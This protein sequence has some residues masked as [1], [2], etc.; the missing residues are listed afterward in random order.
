MPPVDLHDGGSLLALS[1]SLVGP[2]NRLLLALQSLLQPLKLNTALDNFETT[3]DDEGWTTRKDGRGNILPAFTDFSVFNTVQTAELMERVMQVMHILRNFSF[4]EHH[5]RFSYPQHSILTILAK[6][7]ALPSYSWYTEVKQYSLDIFENLAGC[8]QLRGKNDFYLA[9]LKKMIFEQN[10]VIVM[11]ALRS[12]TRLCSNEANHACLSEIDP[13]I[14]SKLFQFLYVKDED[15]VYAILEFIYVHTCLGIDVSSKIASAAPANAI[16]LLTSVLKL[17]TKQNSSHNSMSNLGRSTQ[18]SVRQQNPDEILAVSWLRE[19]YDP[20]PNSVL[21]V[22]DL[23]ADYQSC[24]SR[25]PALT[26]GF[27]RALLFLK[28]YAPGAILVQNEVRGLR[29]RP[30]FVNSGFAGTPTV[31]SEFDKAS[32]SEDEEEIDIDGDEVL[33]EGDAS[34]PNRAHN[35]MMNPQLD[36]SK[37]QSLQG[38]MD[39]I[40]TQSPFQYPNFQTSTNPT[41]PS[42]LPYF[43]PPNM[44]HS[45]SMNTPSAPRRRGR[46]PK[47]RAPERFSHMNTYMGS[48]HQFQVMYAQQGGLHTTPVLENDRRSKDVD[49]TDSIKVDFE[50]SLEDAVFTCFWRM[51]GDKAADMAAVCLVQYGDEEDLMRHVNDE[52]LD[53]YTSDQCCWKNCTKSLGNSSSRQ[54]LLNHLR[55]HVSAPS[56]TAIQTNGTQSSNLEENTD[57]VGIPLTTVLILR[58]LARAPK[59]RDLFA[60]Y[61]NDLV[62]AATRSPKLSKMISEILWELH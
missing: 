35:F 23:K 56:P 41:M 13:E 37:L 60:T 43:V 40:T 16:R 49:R 44:A 61:E 2:H 52:H 3:I 4:L 29:R 26:I 11:G 30:S 15:F 12:L 25:N 62:E 20:S 24:Q 18:S 59:N 21:S 46:P 50:A 38:R 8:L 14:F 10:L 55:T 6:A 47:Q 5:A 1:L 45:A 51:G 39:I 27:E 17:R 54:K 28:R 42:A 34:V 9:C 53:S 19:C 36:Q 7:I 31:A 58:N 57:L 48:P 32:A 33:A 22:Q